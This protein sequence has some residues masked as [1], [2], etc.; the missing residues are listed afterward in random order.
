MSPI[1]RHDF[2]PDTFLH[3]AHMVYDYIIKL[4]QDYDRIYVICDRYFEKSLKTQARDSRGSGNILAFDDDEPFPKNFKESFLKNSTNK[5]NLNHYLALKLLEIHN[6][7]KSFTVTKANTIK[8]NNDSLLLES[9]ISHCDSEEADQKLIRHMI[10]CI[11]SG[12]KHVV[13]KTVDTDV[14]ILAIANRYYAGHFESKV[15]MILGIGKSTKHYDVNAI[16]I[17]LGEEIC[18]ALPFFYSFS[19]SDCVSSFFNQGKCKMWDRWQEFAYRNELTQTFIE[20]SNTP[21]F[22]SPDHLALIEKYI[23]FVYYNKKGLSDDIDNQRMIDF[24]HSIHN[25]LRLIP[26]SKVG[27]IEHTKR[28]SSEAGW[29]AYQCKQNVSLPDPKEWGWILLNGKYIPKW[30]DISNPIDAYFVTQTCSCSTS[31]CLTCHCSKQNLGCL[32]FCKC[33]RKCIYNTV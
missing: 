7:S 33:Q 29:I 8:T 11:R 23:L 16:S 6:A 5:E 25:N 22:V 18:K 10:Q 13:I 1:L 15:Y 17:K 27:L 14:L 9:K 26:P 21:E 24:E 3:F 2:K 19:G 20:L 30:Q 12:V 32:K 28:A 31:K 4:G